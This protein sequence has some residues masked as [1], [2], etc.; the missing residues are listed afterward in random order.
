[1]DGLL[2]IKAYIYMDGLLWIKAYIYMDG[3]LWTISTHLYGWVTMDNKY[4]FIW[5][6]YYGQ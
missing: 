3:L 1:M 4:T 6:G 2:W 5:M